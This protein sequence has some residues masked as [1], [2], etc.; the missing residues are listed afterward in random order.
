MTNV[1][2]KLWGTII[3]KIYC[4]NIKSVYYAGMKIILD[5]V[6]NHS[7]DQ[8]EWFQKSIKKINPYTNYYVWKD[9]KNNNGTT[10]PLPPNNWV[11]NF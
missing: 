7:S 3:N 11:C 6:P 2:Q 10:P 1:E 9:P 8:C 5:F 4:R